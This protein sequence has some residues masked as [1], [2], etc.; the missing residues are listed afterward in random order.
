MLTTKSNELRLSERQKSYWLESSP[1]CTKIVDLDFNLQYMSPAGV[2]DLC[3][4][5]ISPYYGNPYPFE[6]YPKLFRD[7]MIGNLK[8]AKET[9]EV[10]SQEAAVLDIDGNELWFY[11]TIVPVNDENDNLDYLMVVSVNTTEARQGFIQK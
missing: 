9:G 1:V 2:T 5:D 11:S 3:I 8:K 6:F 10:A 7:E 4:A